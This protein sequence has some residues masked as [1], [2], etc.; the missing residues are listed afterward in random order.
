MS[1]N[2]VRA[3][4]SPKGGSQQTNALSKSP[5]KASSDSDGNSLQ[6]IVKSAAKLAEG[7]HT[8]GDEHL[9]EVMT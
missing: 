1:R 4:R 5:S 6:T 3:R 2:R 7:A 8:L 9:H